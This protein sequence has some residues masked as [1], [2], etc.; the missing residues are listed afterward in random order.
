MDLDIKEKV[1]N[2]LDIMVCVQDECK[3]C[4]FRHRKHEDINPY[5]DNYYCF[6]ASQCL[7]SNFSMRKIV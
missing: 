1:E 3:H 2:L 4:C 6:F 7:I 5:Y